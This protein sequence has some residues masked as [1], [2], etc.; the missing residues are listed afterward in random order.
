M[1]FAK[2]HEYLIHGFQCEAW[3]DHGVPDESQM[4]VME[5]LFT[6]FRYLRSQQP[7]D[8]TTVVHCS[9]G[10]GRTGAFLAIVAVLEQIE[11]GAFKLANLEYDP[12]RDYSR[13]VDQPRAVSALPANWMEQVQISPYK[14][15]EGLRWQRPHM[16]QTTVQY[17]FVSQFVLHCL[18]SRNVMVLP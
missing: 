9:A 17:S 2:S 6:Q 3:P 13:H 16:V 5:Y 15:V 11:R 7:L 14:V 4:K 10:I 8:H 1:L 18:E 12:S